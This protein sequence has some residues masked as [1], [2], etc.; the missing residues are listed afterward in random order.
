M[1]T[2]F[3]IY[4][5]LAFKMS[6]WSNAA[7]IKT[8]W[9][10][11]RCNLNSVMLEDL[12]LC[13]Y[14]I[15]KHKFICFHVMPWMPI[16]AYQDI[17]PLEIPILKYWKS[18]CRLTSNQR[19][20]WCRALSSFRLLGHAGKQKVSQKNFPQCICHVSSETYPKFLQVYLVTP[21]HF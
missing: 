15:I 14:E 11:L 7:E 3:T 20:G 13:K 19:Y 17:Y 1:H 4:F 16:L 6:C 9:I 18:K 21:K 12:K 5:F 10:C 2:A 8:M